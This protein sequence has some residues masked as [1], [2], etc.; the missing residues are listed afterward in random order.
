MKVSLQQ[1]QHLWRLVDAPPGA[2]VSDDIVDE[3]LSRDHVTLAYGERCFELTNTVEAGGACYL[4]LVEIGRV[5][6]SGSGAPILIFARHG[7]RAEQRIVP[8]CDALDRAVL[9]DIGARALSALGRALLDD[10]ARVIDGE[11]PARVSAR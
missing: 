4:R 3:A 8:C 2:A 5:T 7:Y 10:T 9:P 6:D 1:P 11:E